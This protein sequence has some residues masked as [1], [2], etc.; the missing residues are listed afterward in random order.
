MP[1]AAKPI[2]TTRV[3][4]TRGIRAM[5]RR[6]NTQWALGATFGVTD[7]TISKIVNRKERYADIT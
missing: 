5:Y 6:G 3:Q 4:A 1:T 2:A 7:G